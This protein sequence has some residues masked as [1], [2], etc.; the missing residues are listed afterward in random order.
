VNVSQATQAAAIKDV[1]DRYALRIAAPSDAPV[2]AYHRASMFYDMGK[3][4]KAQAAALESASRLHVKQWLESGEYRGWL[5]ENGNEVVAGGGIIFRR[6]L[7]AP[8]HVNGGIE[9]RVLNV[10]TEPNH[11]RRGLAGKIVMAILDWCNANN[12]SCVTLHASDDGRALYESLGFK[13]TNEMRFHGP[14]Y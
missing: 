9:A 11:R 6:L 1:G 7:P 12:I 8:D 13:Q 4:D 3:I 5:I 14:R 2:I 10:Y